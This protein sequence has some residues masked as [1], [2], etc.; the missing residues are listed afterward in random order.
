MGG[1][2]LAR[3]ALAL[4]QHVRAGLPH[5]LDGVVNLLHP[6]ADP[7]QRVVAMPVLD[8]GLQDDLLLLELL[9]VEDSVDDDL[10]HVQLERFLKVVVAAVLHG[11][12][13]RLHGPMAGHDD[14]L[15]LGTVFL[16]GREQLQAVD[17]RHLDV[18][19]NDLVGLV[20]DPLQGRQ[21]VVHDV[22]LVADLREVLP[23]DLQYGAIVVH[24][25]NVRNVHRKPPLNAFTNRR[26][27]FSRL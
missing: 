12:D 7:H 4:D 22:D 27:G 9:L 20:L 2:L 15:G 11:L 8:P 6:E 16:D 3:A 10:Q 21:P 26:S 14:H 1:E 13:G 23:D 5:A 19:E 18:G 24:E 25:E 17:V